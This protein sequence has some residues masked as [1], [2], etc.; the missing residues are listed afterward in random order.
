MC[1]SSRVVET[2]RGQVVVVHAGTVS[3]CEWAL[4]PPD[5]GV[6][7]QEFMHF[8]GV[9]N[10]NFDVVPYYRNARNFCVHLIKTFLLRHSILHEPR[11]RATPP[12]Y[13]CLLH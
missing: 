7:V 11:E 10:V 8:R 6:R 5:N 9:A 12:V 3:R 13:K 4:I 1:V 2:G